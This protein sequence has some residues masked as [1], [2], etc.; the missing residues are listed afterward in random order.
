MQEYINEI[1]NNSSPRKSNCLISE[2][3]F[4]NIHFY[5]NINISMSLQWRHNGCDSVSNHQPHDCFSTIYSDT[6]QW[7]HQSSALLA[8]CAGNSP[9]AGEFPAQ[10]D[11]N[12][13]NVSI[14]WRHH[15][16][17]KFCVYIIRWLQN[18]IGSF[19]G[20]LSSSKKWLP[21]PMLIK[22]HEGMI[23]YSRTSCFQVYEIWIKVG[24]QAKI[25]SVRTP[26]YS[27]NERLPCRLNP[28]HRWAIIHKPPARTT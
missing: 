24:W 8:L 10:M 1:T 11:S 18:N 3:Y 22:T 2:N 16:K 15:V 25:S 14:W 7:K 13:E 20:F 17:L 19:N 6:D 4:S 28:L 9:E 21:E 26:N 23:T 12:A 27:A 5:I